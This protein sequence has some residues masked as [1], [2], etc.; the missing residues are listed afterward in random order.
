M[1]CSWS[2]GS[3][4]PARLV[5]L[6][7][8]EICTHIIIYPPGLSLYLFK[9][10]LWHDIPTCIY[11]YIFI[12]LLLLLLL[13]SFLLLLYLILYIYSIYIY[14]Y[15]L[16]YIILYIYIYIVYIFPCFSAGVLAPQTWLHGFTPCPSWP[17]GWPCSNPSPASEPRRAPAPPCASQC[18]GKAPPSP[19]RWRS[20]AAGGSA[21]DGPWQ[22]P[23]NGLGIGLEQVGMGWKS[24]MATKK[25]TNRREK[26]R[27][28]K[29][30]WEQH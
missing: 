9:K 4:G 1:C 18:P 17:T 25:S 7:N 14:I 29:I 6:V 12:Y 10:S 13:L 8:P 20:L 28:P 24:G 11:I 3:Q 26:N 5:N 16:L 27:R 19:S 21:G 2:T 30:S 23:G 22:R 15:L